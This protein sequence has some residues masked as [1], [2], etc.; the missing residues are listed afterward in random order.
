MDIQY[1]GEISTILTSYITKYVSKPAKS[2]LSDFDIATIYSKNNE[3][4]SLLS[5]LWNFSLRATCNR[6]CGA[7]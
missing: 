4:K 3:N 6:E 2:E 7:L 1:I 5:I